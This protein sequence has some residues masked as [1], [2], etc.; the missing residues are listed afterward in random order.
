MRA[1]FPSPVEGGSEEMGELGDRR[2]HELVRAYPELLPFF[3][4]LGLSPSDSGIR[5]L[6]KTAA[7]RGE[8]FAELLGLVA[9]R[10]RQEE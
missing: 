8:A 9:W 2:I 3:R 1:L 5:P 4:R 7:A 6:R 10:F